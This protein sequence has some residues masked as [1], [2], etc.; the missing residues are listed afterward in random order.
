MPSESVQK[1]IGRAISDAAFRELL[2]G[3][4][5]QALAEYNLSA[6]EITAL[7]NLK[8][9]EFDA[10]AELEQRVSKAAPFV[11]GGAVIGA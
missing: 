8:R 9:E 5:D 4:P 7:K 1:I 2:L 6:E 10:P 3:N 11:P